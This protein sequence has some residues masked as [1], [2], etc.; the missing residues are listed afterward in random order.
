VSEVPDTV[1]LV[2]EYFS[3]KSRAATEKYFWKNSVAAYKW[4]R[5]SPDQ[6]RI[7]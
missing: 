2:R 7:S 5:R 3:G 6:P 4:I 1:S